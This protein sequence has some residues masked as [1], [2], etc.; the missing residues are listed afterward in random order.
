MSEISLQL[1]HIRGVEVLCICQSK[2]ASN[3]KEEKPFCFK[4]TSTG[5]LCSKET[6]PSEG[7]TMGVYLGSYGDPR[8][9]GLFHMSEVPLYRPGK[10]ANERVP[11]YL[12]H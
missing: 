3:S 7:P 1:R 2:P 10:T 4:T 9:G 6:A 8:G 12:S 5:V 11:G